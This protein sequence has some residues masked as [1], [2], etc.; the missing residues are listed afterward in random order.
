MGEF[1]CCFCPNGI[2][3]HANTIGECLISKTNF[4]KHLSLS[5]KRQEWKYQWRKDQ[6]I[7]L[8]CGV[9]YQYYW[10][11]K[12]LVLASCE[13]DWMMKMMEAIRMIRIRKK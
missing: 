9:Y 12:T 1:Y 10:N 8:F 3:E 7:L 6:E 2:W 5:H 4:V 13:N 11:I